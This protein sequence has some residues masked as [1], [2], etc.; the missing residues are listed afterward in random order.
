MH[1]EQGRLALLGRLISLSPSFST[2]AFFDSFELHLAKPVRPK[3]YIFLVKL[4]F[5]MI[6]FYIIIILF[7]RKK[8]TRVSCVYEHRLLAVGSAA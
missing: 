2:R 8:K 3:Y 6:V 7:W 4:L 5:N 1:N